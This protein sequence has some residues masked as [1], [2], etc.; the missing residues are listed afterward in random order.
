V[1]QIRCDLNWWTVQPKNATTYDWSKYD[2]V[3]NAA[4]HYGI[5][6]LFTIAWTPPWA[7]PKTLPKGVHD[8]S[9][10]PP[11]RTSDYV[12]FANAAVN[13]YS[14]VGKA[15]VKSVVGTVS[16]WEIWNE[17]NLWSGWTPPNPVGYG[18]VLKVVAT[19]IHKLDPKAIVVLGGMAPAVTKGG[20]YSFTDFITKLA[21]TGALKV[22]NAVGIHP[23]TFPAWP[24][25]QIKF[26]PFY[27]QVPKMYQVMSKNGAGTKK[28]WITETGW[29]TASKS[30]E[31][32][33]SNGT[34]V[35]TESYQAKELPLL[36]T[37]WFKFSYAGPLF[38][39]AERD[40]CT[41]NSNWLCKMGIERIDGSQK[42]AWKTVHTQLGKPIQH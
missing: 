38:L 29:P 25:E 16:Q 37:T 8:A 42:P 26:N 33:R 19:S 1:S 4:A 18:T 14:P 10:V 39:Y 6:I 28:I 35:G 11:V 20:S 31:T 30:K 32:V 34:Q 12:T 5:K 23:Y 3:V 36:L 27:N 7:R 40:R 15:R 24:N 17:E 2:Q 21:P 22:V 13:R 41:S 9:H